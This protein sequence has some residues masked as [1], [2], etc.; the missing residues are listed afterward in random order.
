MQ[1]LVVVVCCLVLVATAVASAQLSPAELM[2]LERILADYETVEQML[3]EGL[4][5]LSA[6]QIA[7]AQGLMILHEGSGYLSQQISALEH[8]LNVIEE[9]NQAQRKRNRKLVLIL[10]GVLTLETAAIIIWR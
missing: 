10:G 1:R 2:E 4:T 7:L 5:R 6:G 8:S 9:A 3:T